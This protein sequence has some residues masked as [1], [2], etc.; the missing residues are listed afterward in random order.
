MSAEQRETS[1]A[2][3]THNITNGDQ[4]YFLVA[5]SGVM[6]VGFCTLGM[7]QLLL[8]LGL[9]CLGAVGVTFKLKGGFLFVLLV[10]VLSEIY[11]R[12]LGSM[13]T[14]QD[15]FRVLRCVGLLAFAIGHYRRLAIVSNLIPIDTRIREKPPPRRWFRRRGKPKVIG[16]TPEGVTITE[17]ILGLLSVPTCVGIGLFLWPRL[18]FLPDTFELE[19]NAPLL[20]RVIS[21]VIFCLGLMVWVFILGNLLKY[22]QRSS[23]PPE[24]T[25][26]FLQDVLWRETRRE[27][28]RINQWVARESHP[29][30]EDVELRDQKRLDHGDKP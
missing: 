19:R 25:A 1:E 14:V 7:S 3:E 6:L 10:V 30:R 8:G 17:I 24:E 18:M 11:Q 26:M 28:R 9:L 12:L 13:T 2:S 20:G 22:W 21:I 5:M 23:A 27:Q 16:R 4:T 15:L 29:F